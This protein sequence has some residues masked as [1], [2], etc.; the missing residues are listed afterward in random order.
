[1]SASVRSTRPSTGSRSNG[2]SSWS[3]V[4]GFYLMDFRCDLVSRLLEVLLW[5][6]TGM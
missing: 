4:L 1:M 6:L 3:P 5:R 2:S